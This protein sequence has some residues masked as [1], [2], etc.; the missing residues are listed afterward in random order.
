MRSEGFDKAGV[1]QFSNEVKYNDKGKWSEQTGYDKDR[2]ITYTAAITYNYYLIGNWI[3]LF[4]KPIKM[5][6]LSLIEP[7]PIFDHASHMHFFKRPTHN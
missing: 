3:K 2:K 7:I 4:L 6:L 1:F 5:R